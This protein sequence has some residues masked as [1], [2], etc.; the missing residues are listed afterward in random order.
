LWVLGALAL[1]LVVP[2][3]FAPVATAAPATVDSVAVTVDQDGSA[4]FTSGFDDGPNNGI[5]PTADSIVYRVSTQLQTAG[6][7]Q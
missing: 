1:G 5:A 4:P 7:V 2:M 6:D 3:A